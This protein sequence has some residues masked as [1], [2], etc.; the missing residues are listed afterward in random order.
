MGEFSGLGWV[1]RTGVEPLALVNAVRREIE[2]LDPS[3]A[4]TD[5]RLMDDYVKEARAPTRFALVLIGVFGLAALILASVGL[6]G[7][8]SYLVRQR[9]SEIGIRMAFGAGR[10]QILKLVVGQGMVLALVG[11]G[12]GVVSAFGIT[13]VMTSML[14]DVAPTDPLTFVTI[15]ALFLLVALVA[16]YLPASRATRVD[17]MVALR[18]E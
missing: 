6:Y 8:L 5:M 13:R 10:T 7:V 1:V 15:S 3:L 12:I 16:C 18:N 2:A 11:L 9:T 14:V 17:P 4:V